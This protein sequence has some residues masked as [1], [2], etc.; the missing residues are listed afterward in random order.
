MHGVSAIPTSEI[1]MI[2][3]ANKQN[4][5]HHCNRFTETAAGIIQQDLDLNSRR[6]TQLS[7]H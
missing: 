4:I 2:E 1:A 5:E 3:A 7:F 6:L